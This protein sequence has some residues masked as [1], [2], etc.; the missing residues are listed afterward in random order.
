MAIVEDNNLKVVYTIVEISELYIKSQLK[1]LVGD[2]SLINPKLCKY[3]DCFSI[4]EDCDD[5][6]YHCITRV[7]QTNTVDGISDVDGSVDIGIYPN[8]YTPCLPFTKHHINTY[9]LDKTHSKVDDYM[10]VFYINN[11]HLGNNQ[12]CNGF[13]VYLIVKEAILQKFLEDIKL[14][15]SQID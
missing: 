5:G 12:S 15:I 8:E 1:F 11:F 10:L 3:G 13:S 4:L 6:L 9:S 7:L 14:E 2:E